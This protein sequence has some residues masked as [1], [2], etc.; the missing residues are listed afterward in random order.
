MIYGYGG[1]A[2]EVFQ[3]V[4]DINVLKPE[5]NVLGFI[6]D[7]PTATG[8][9]TQGIP[10][11]GGMEWLIEKHHVHVII[12]IGSSKTRFHIVQKMRT[13]CTNSFATLIH[14]LALIGDRVEVEDGTIICA[15]TSITTDVAVGHH[16]ILN[17]SCTVGH[18]SVLYDFVTV[19]PNVSISGNVSIEE[20]CE[21]GT[22]S[23]IVPG[24]SVGSWSIV[25]A[26]TVVIKNV[27]PNATIVGNPGRVVSQRPH[28]WQL[29][30]VD[31]N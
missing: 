9:D 4:K 10:I 5:W 27:E 23:T 24:K 15:G 20:G 30:D 25:G 17:L 19:S 31:P 12:A 21:L 22:T 26:G 16:V 3:L 2:R 11:L 6:D 29:E 7:D 14:P 13:Y 28:G 1:F 18:D 8:S